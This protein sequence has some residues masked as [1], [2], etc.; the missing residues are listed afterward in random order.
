MNFCILD[1]KEGTMR[2]CM[3]LRSSFCTL[4]I[5][6]I[7]LLSQAVNKCILDYSSLTLIGVPFYDA[8]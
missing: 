2:L 8:E 7:N 4:I 6:I 5:I 3:L 1:N